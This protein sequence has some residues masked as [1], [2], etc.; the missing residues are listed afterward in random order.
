[1]TEHHEQEKKLPRDRHFNPWRT[2]VTAPAQALVADVRERYLQHESKVSPR[3][4][5]RRSPDQ[6]VF[7]HQIE[8]IVS[9][10]A[11]EHLVNPER[12]VST[13]FSKTKLGNQGRYGVPMLNNTF[14]KIIKLLA[15]PELGAVDMV[16][17]NR[18]DWDGDGVK[19][20]T[21]KASHQLVKLIGGYGLSI[22]D[23]RE[24][25]TGEVIVLKRERE[26]IFDDN[27]APIPYEDT[28]ETN[29]YR[30]E[31]QRINRWLDQAD[32][33]FDDTLSEAF[34]DARDRHLR[35]IFN[36]GS[37]AQGGRLFG[38]FWQRLPKHLRR[39]GITINGNQ[40]TTLDFGQIAPRIMY[41]MSGAQPAFEDAYLLPTINAKYRDGIKK[42]F[43][44]LLCADKRPTRF[45]Q[46]TRNL[47]PNTAIKVDQVIDAIL[48]THAS[49]APL[50]YSDQ[51][52][53]VMYKESQIL[54]SIL[55]RLIDESIVGLPIHD[56]LVVDE[57]DAP[58]VKEI[59]IN[60]FK[61][62]TGVSIPVTTD[63]D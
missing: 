53:S 59:M 56:A 25:N 33:E 55:G 10:L 29:R 14:P 8:A 47:I 16:W 57:H 42:V 19:Q 24:V 6:L 54:V 15:D 11:Y 37:F 36:N 13:T 28:E 52:L 58:L 43:N 20:T 46:G 1:M 22:S 41:G 23:F 4:R 51:G 38:G 49:I 44:A 7:D 32:I 50:F 17:G 31:I 12:W 26:N 34:I 48:A 3:T 35:R 9:D 45:P 21:I 63:D 61:D 30:A 2:A 5:A 18:F 40:V 27:K 62:H 39:R 60:T